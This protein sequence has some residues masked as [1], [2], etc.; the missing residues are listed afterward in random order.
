MD[1][2]LTRSG[3]FD[4][5]LAIPVPDPAGLAEIYVKLIRQLIATHEVAGFRMFTD[6]LDPRSLAAASHGM[7]GADVKEV[8]RRAQ[9]AKAMQE[10][11]TGSPAGPI[12]QQDLESRIAELRHRAA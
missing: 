12:S 5:K 3:R 4:V 9:L 11:R 1:E 7:T 6:D 8:L 10:A 2:S